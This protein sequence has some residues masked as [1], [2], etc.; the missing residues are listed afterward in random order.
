MAARTTKIRQ[1]E[2]TR[3]KIQ[4][5][6]LINRLT[7]HVFGTLE[8][9]LDATQVSAALGLLKKSLPDLSATNVS[10]DIFNH[11]FVVSSDPMGIDDWRNQYEN[12]LEAAEGAAES[13]H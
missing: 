2:E 3:L 10:G 1:T 8:K 9:P 11:H 12:S 7:A 5:S 13:T 6:Q 4:T